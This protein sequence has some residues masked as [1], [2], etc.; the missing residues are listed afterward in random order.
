MAVN[1]LAGV[2]LVAVFVFA[3]TQFHPI[4]HWHTPYIRFMAFDKHMNLV[5]GDCEE[6]RRLPPKKGQT[7]EVRGCNHGGVYTTQCAYTP[8]PHLLTA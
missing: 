8:S 6:F 5:L 4:I 1:S 2:L 7:E 3:T